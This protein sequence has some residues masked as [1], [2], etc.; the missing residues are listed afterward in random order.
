MGSSTAAEESIEV[1]FAHDSEDDEDDVSINNPCYNCHG[2]ATAESF[3]AC[4]SPS[5]GYVMLR[6]LLFAK[7]VTVM[8]SVLNVLTNSTVR[9]EK[10]INLHDYPSSLSHHEVVMYV[11]KCK[12]PLNVSTAP[13]Y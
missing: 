2:I 6:Q 1:D 12:I 4:Y 11:R 7:N 13:I 3:F 5:A 8:N 9:L 10:P